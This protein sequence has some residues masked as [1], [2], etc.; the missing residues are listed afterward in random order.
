MP[1]LPATGHDGVFIPAE[2][3]ANSATLSYFT[4]PAWSEDA[5]GNLQVNVDLRLFP[6]LFENPQHFTELHLAAIFEGAAACA[7][8]GQ[9][10][11]LP[12]ILQPLN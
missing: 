7:S 9:P 12:L 11:S 5:D 6:V 3:L 2:R 1:S 4:G 10:P 8:V